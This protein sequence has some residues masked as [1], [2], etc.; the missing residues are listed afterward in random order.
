MGGFQRKSWLW[1]RAPASA[2]R[3]ESQSDCICLSWISLRH[4]GNGSLGL[5]F[6]KSKAI[7][8]SF[9]SQLSFDWAITWEGTAKTAR[10]NSPT[11][12]KKQ[13]HRGLGHLRLPLFLAV[14]TGPFIHSFIHSRVQ[15]AIDSYWTGEKI[16]CFQCHQLTQGQAGGTITE[17]KKVASSGLSESMRS[18][19]HSIQQWRANICSCLP[20]GILS[21]FPSFILKN[22]F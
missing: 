4:L 12:Y 8:C 22:Y 10:G 18:S 2:P 9:W 7:P 21:L 13:P 11:G 20:K 14:N 17:P 1:G 19:L 15:S 5:S 3:T 16:W 6:P